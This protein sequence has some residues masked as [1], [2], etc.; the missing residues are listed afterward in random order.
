MCEGENSNSNSTPDPSS[1]SESD[2]VGSQPK[3][4]KLLQPIDIKILENNP[5]L[6]EMFHAVSSAVAEKV[7]L[8][9]ETGIPSQITAG[10]AAGF[11]MGFAVKKSL[12]L[13]AILFGV[14]L[15]FIQFLSYTGYIQTDWKTLSDD[16]IGKFDQNG[17]GKV[18]KEDMEIL[19]SQISE[20]VG[21]NLPAGSGWMA[22]WLAGLRTG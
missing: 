20:V 4:K 15:F 9:I 10:F 17:D 18:D 11:C 2:D 8:I 21:Y 6:Q 1:Q 12:K 7:D 5:K 22:G 13:F 3:K 14:I 19:W 16:F